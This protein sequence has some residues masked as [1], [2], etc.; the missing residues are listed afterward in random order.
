MRDYA[1]LLESEEAKRKF[2]D[3]HAMTK[4]RALLPLLDCHWYGVRGQGVSEQTFGDTRPELKADFSAAIEA[5]CERLAKEAGLVEPQPE[6]KEEGHSKDAQAMTPESEEQ[7]QIDAFAELQRLAEIGRAVKE[8]GVLLGE[9]GS[10]RCVS[11]NPKETHW[12]AF[13]GDIF[14]PIA[15]AES[16]PALLAAV[17]ARLAEKEKQS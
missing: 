3:F 10:S 11:I 8:L 2:N 12:G 17:K 5:E 1:A 15:T 14:N 4:L 13:I 7:H 16:A 6:S 9:R